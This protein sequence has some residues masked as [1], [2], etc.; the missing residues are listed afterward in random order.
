VS[1][2][3]RTMEYNKRLARRW[4][5]LVSAR[6]VEALC[7]ATAPTW[8]M[9]GGPP[10]LP[11]GPDGVR[12]LFATFGDAIDQTWTVDAVVA[13]GD[14]VVVRATNRCMQDSCFGIPGRGRVQTFTAM[15]MHRVVDGL[16]AETWRNANDLGRVLQLGAPRAARP[17]LTRRGGAAR[18]LPSP[19]GPLHGTHPVV[20]QGGGRT[21]RGETVR[22]MDR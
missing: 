19:A 3:E 14:T 20:G 18:H 4:L 13:E 7:A 9:H 16:V 11:P 2:I 10:G 5:E 8:T 22:R 1:T 6:D 17:E 15:F 21:C 12:A